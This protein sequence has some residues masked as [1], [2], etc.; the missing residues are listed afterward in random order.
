M[1]EANENDIVKSNRKVSEK[2]TPSKS[3]D[4]RE[5]TRVFYV[6]IDKLPEDIPPTLDV[7]LTFTPKKKGPFN[8]FS[9]TV[10][11]PVVSLDPETGHL[12]IL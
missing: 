7:Y 10:H 12:R 3:L 1:L 6:N 4:I 8:S 5:V 11:V 2:G 9:Q